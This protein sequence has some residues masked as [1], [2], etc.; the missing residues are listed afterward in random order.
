MA[1][2]GIRSEQKVVMVGGENAIRIRHNP[3][4]PNL[5]GS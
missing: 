3:L 5:K 2:Q 4:A 1:S